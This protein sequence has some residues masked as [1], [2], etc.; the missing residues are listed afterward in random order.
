MRLFGKKTPP[1][2]PKDADSFTLLAMA[3]NTQDPAIKY[4]L[5]LQAEEKDPDNLKVQHAL[6]MHGRLHERDPRRVNFSVIKC[7]MLH[8][9]EHP[10]QHE[11][12]DIRQK[13]RALFDEER[14]QKCLALA[15][16]PDSYLRGYIEELSLEYIRLFLEGDASNVPSLFGITRKHSIARY[17]SK[18]MADMVQ[19]MLSSAY[20]R[21]QEQQ[22]LAGMFYRACHRYLNGQTEHLDSLLSPEIIKALI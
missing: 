19:N 13:T 22:L 20:L 7:Y 5:L 11:E 14:L 9:Y 8:V 3:K 2:P 21:M 4:Q 18:P 15:P 10:E 16:H 17:L 6:L 12:E 1:Q